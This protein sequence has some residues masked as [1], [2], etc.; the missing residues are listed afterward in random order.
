MHR[1]LYMFTPANYGSLRIIDNWILQCIVRMGQGISAASPWFKPWLVVVCKMPCV[2]RGYLLS[3]LHLVVAI[4]AIRPQTDS[5]LDEHHE[6][7]I[8]FHHIISY[9][10][11][12]DTPIPSY[13]SWFLLDSSLNLPPED[14]DPILDQS[15]RASHRNPWQISDPWP[16]IEKCGEL[17]HD[18]ITLH[19]SALQHDRF[20]FHPFPIG[21]V[22]KIYKILQDFTR[23]PLISYIP[24]TSEFAQN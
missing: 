6:L 11:I 22:D 2:H 7:R 14:L 18:G 12:K 20:L 13:S 23:L 19:G 17:G 15:F 16:E 3:W 4:R 8:W 1:K 9:M 5:T 21:W 10:K 24:V